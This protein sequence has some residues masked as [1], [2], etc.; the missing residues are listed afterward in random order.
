M[1]YD[2][3]R[4]ALSESQLPKESLALA[5]A[6]LHGP[7]TLQPFN[8]RLTIPEIPCHALGL[9]RFPQNHSKM[10]KLGLREPGRPSGSFSFD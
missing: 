6:Q 2:W 4:L 7:V 3:T 8:Q 1:G 5:N 9:R 10:L